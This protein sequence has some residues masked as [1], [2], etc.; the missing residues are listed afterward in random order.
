MSSL[1]GVTDKAPARRHGPVRAGSNSVNGHKNGIVQ[2]RATVCV[3]GYPYASVEGR[4][5][6]GVMDRS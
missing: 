2:E 6:P 5:P 1:V 4:L 3:A